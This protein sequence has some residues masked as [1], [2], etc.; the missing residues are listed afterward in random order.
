MVPFLQEQWGNPSSPYRFGSKVRE[1][2]ERARR[3]VA[4]G[5][6][7]LPDE[8]LFCPSGTA[9]DN[10][11]I[12]GVA[13][14]MRSRGRHIVTSVIEHPAVLNTC[15]AL[16]KDGFRLTCLPVDQNGVVLLDA[17][18]RCMDEETILVTVMH[19]NNETGVVQPI[20]RIAEMTRPRGIL[21]H[22][23]AVQTAGRLPLPIGE[24]GVDLLTC[25]GHKLYGPKG[26]AALYVRAGTPLS[27]VTTGGSQEHGLNAGTENV[28]G[29]MGLAEALKL[30]NEDKNAE[31]PRLRVLRDRLERE[32]AIVG[33]ASD[34]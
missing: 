34:H 28:A 4:D 6:G 27:P 15:K 7:C 32:L 30:A 33:D 20:E 5:I 1:A 31:G 23:D 16:E 2:V 9:S 24:R 21:L 13:H 29:I 10:L 18:D 12:R 26:A 19:A 14:A 25:T 22:T 3:S 17:L 11:A 8:I